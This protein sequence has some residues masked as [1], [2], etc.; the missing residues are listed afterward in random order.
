MSKLFRRQK[1]PS[2]GDETYPEPDL[3]AIVPMVEIPEIIVPE[4]LSLKA[5][6]AMAFNPEKV[7]YNDDYAVGLAEDSLE[8]NEIINN[9]A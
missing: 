8:A 5:V 3:R 4:R 2:E 7:N 1:K 6:K 9:N